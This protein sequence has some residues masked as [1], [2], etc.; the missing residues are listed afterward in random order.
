MAKQSID[1]GTTPN[2]GTG[3]SLRDSLDICN[4]N[5]TE[6]YNRLRVEAAAPTVNDDIDHATPVEVGCIWVDTSATSPQG[7]VY[8]CR[9]N[10]NG[11]AV[12]QVI[13]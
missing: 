5:F 9:D 7:S 1:L 8:I 4:D 2:D 10:T 6:L 3:T 13:V 11:A 12:W